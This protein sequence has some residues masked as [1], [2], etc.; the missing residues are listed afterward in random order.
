MTR[1]N[2]DGYTVETFSRMTVFYKGENVETSK[3]PRNTA[4]FL[5]NTNDRKISRCAV[6]LGADDNISERI[7]EECRKNVWHASHNIVIILKSDLEDSVEK[8]LMGSR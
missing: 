1:R 3:L 8:Y 4:F 6:I 5:Y 2:G 7:G